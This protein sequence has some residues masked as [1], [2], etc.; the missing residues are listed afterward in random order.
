MSL[1]PFGSS[2]YKTT[3]QLNAEK[4][5]GTEYNAAK[6]AAEFKRSMLGNAGTSIFNNHATRPKISSGYSHQSSANFTS[7][8]GSAPSMWQ[9]SSSAVGSSARGSQPE[10]PNYKADN[11][12]VF[13]AFIQ[14]RIMQSLDGETNRVRRFTIIFYTQDETVE[15]FEKKQDNSGISQGKFLKRCDLRKSGG[16]YYQARDF[17]IGQVLRIHG[18][19]F[20]ICGCNNAFTEHKYFEIHGVS[21]YTGNN[22]NQVDDEFV[23]Y[24]SGASQNQPPS[25]TAHVP[26]DAYT[27]KRMQMEQRD[28]TGERLTHFGKQTSEINAYSE[29]QLGNTM[30]GI[31]RR[32][33]RPGFNQPATDHNRKTQIY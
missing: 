13:D 17:A 9:T 6:K 15:I 26:T 19:E 22:E 8:D 20:T 21:A 30:Y 18:H 25:P 2:M 3:N 14:E 23:G 27:L 24:L 16:S 10:A 1:T 4:V 7:A 31:N 33:A 32:A 29:A 28:A 12:L 11:K 5:H